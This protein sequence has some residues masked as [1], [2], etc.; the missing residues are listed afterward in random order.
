MLDSHGTASL[1]GFAYYAA[2]RDDGRVGSCFSV[3]DLSRTYGMT[4]LHS[5]AKEITHK[6]HANSVRFWLPLRVDSLGKA[7]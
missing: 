3:W 2:T 7:V 1:F 4:A 6:S 5:L